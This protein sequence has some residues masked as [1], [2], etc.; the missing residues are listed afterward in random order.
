M[1]AHRAKNESEVRDEKS[2]L[3][4][5]T[6]SHRAIQET[7]ENRKAKCEICGD[8]FTLNEISCHIC[9]GKKSIEC[10]YCKISF[11]AVIRLVPHLEKHED[12]TLHRCRKCARLFGMIQLRDW[13]ENNHKEEFKPF[14]CE[15]CS[16]G[17]KDKHAVESHLSTHSDESK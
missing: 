16:K 17:F 8:Y 1:K 10:E 12:R 5:H 11:N 14:L 3:A 4:G 2:E 9:D 7:T 15:I 13:H 6:T